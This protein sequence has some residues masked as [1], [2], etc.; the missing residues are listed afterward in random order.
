MNK[1]PN[2]V[3]VKEAF[4]KPQGYLT[5]TSANIK[6]RVETVAEY[7]G[8]MSHKRILDIGCGDGSLSLNLL[9]ATN[10]VTL[11]DRSQSMLAR[12]A[13][14][15]PKGLE[16]RVTIINS[17]FNAYAFE[18]N[19]FDL[20]ICVGVLAYVEDLKPFLTRITTVLAPGGTAV[21]ECSDG[22]H[23][24]RRIGRAYD[25]IRRIFG[26]NDFQTVR[27]PR[28]D[29][30]AA[31]DALGFTPRSSWRYSYPL[32]VVRKLLT[33]SMIYGGTHLL[34]GTPSRNRNAWAGSECIFHFVRR[35]GTGKGA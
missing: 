12:A 33:Q 4:E 11:L 29:V 16:G 26:A 28:S 1:N 2:D 13:A 21:V 17:D 27:R 32:P 18:P 7:V 24:M 6:M 30:I 31:F 35:E 9:N 19:S 5:R 14:S 22:S 25:R 8:D 10:H 23:F 34:Y 15:V 3:L 20:V